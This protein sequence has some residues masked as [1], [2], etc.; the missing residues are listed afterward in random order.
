[1]KIH[2]TQFQQ[3]RLSLPDSFQPTFDMFLEMIE[4][5]PKIVNSVDN[6]YL[7]K[8]LFSP[9]IRFLISKYVAEKKESFLAMKSQRQKREVEDA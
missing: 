4:H 2:K 7:Y 6:K 8:G 3:Q 9:A 1:M 5:D